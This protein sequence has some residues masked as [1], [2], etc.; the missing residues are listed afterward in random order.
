MS[1]IISLQNAATGLNIA[2][3]VYLYEDKR[4]NIKYVAMLNNTISISPP[5]DYENMNHFLLGYSRCMNLLIT[6]L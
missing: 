1:Q 2:I 4:K 6:K 5:L 3:K